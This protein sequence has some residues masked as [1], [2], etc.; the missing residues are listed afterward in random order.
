MHSTWWN[1]KAFIYCGRIASNKGVDIII[2]A[3]IKLKEKYADNCPSLWIV[4]HS[5][6]F[7]SQTIRYYGMNKRYFEELAK[8]SC[9]L[10][11]IPIN[12]MN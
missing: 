9:D 5:C 12:T 4:G 2:K 3:W 8:F 10:S 6:F 7:S 1:K 11:R